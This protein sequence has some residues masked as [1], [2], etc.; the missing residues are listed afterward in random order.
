[1]LSSLRTRTPL[2]PTAAALVGATI[3]GLAAGA[4]SFALFPITHGADFA[5][6]HYHARA[7]LAGRDP[8]LGGYPI[9]RT[10]RVVP[11]PFFYPFPTLLAIAPFAWLPLPVATAAFVALSSGLLGYVVLR[12]APHQLPLFLGAGFIVALGLGQWTP[13]VTATFVLPAIAWLAVLKPNVGLAVTVAKPSRLGVLGGAA[14]LVLTLAIQP[15]WPAEWLRN[16]RSMPGHPT[17]LLT[18]GGFLLLLALLRW[19]RSEARLVAAMALVPQLMYFCDQLPLWLVPRTRRESMVLSA[20]SLIAWLAAMVLSARADRQPAFNSTWFVLAGV[21]LPT[22]LMVLRRPNE[23]WLPAGIE[24]RIVRLPKWLQGTQQ[25]DA[26]ALT[27][28]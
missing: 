28:R 7:W 4:V 8:Y 12:R 17:P 27:R 15:T 10:T 16:L 1:M 14:L 3:I 13:I 21:Y 18:P 20:T 11:E 23:G 2:P 6:F 19:R 24:R 22:L 9:M 25:A 26:K 5:Q